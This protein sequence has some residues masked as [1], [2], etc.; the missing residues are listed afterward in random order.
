MKATETKKELTTKK[1]TVNKGTK[2]SK[3]ETVMKKNEVAVKEAKAVAVKESKAVENSAKKDAFLSIEEITKL[4]QELG[5]KCANPQA[6][7]NYRIMGSKSS[8]NVKPKKGY[9]IYTADSDY[10]ELTKAELKFEDLIVEKGTNSQDKTRP[11]TVICTTLET[12]K[13]V[14]AVFAKNP[15]NNVA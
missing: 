7:G 4:Y 5:I 11:N 10:E 15:L 14:L 13:A 12:L 8:L 6:K 1:A 9:Y 3:E 2:V